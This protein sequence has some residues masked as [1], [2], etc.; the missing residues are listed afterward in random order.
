M[1]SHSFFAHFNCSFFTPVFQRPYLMLCSTHHRPMYT[2]DNDRCIPTTTIDAD[3]QPR[4][5]YTHNHARGSFIF[6]WAKKLFLLDV[7]TAPP[8]ERGRFSGSQTF[9]S[10]RKIFFSG[11]ATARLREIILLHPGHNFVFSSRQ[12]Y[13]A[14]VKLSVLHYNTFIPHNSKLILYNS[15]IPHTS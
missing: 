1:P 6:C 8:G 13:S 12:H 3:L 4:A 15:F 7:S 11:R 5:W 2:H 10:P 9:F 14:M